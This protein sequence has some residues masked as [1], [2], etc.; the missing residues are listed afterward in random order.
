VSTA[1]PCSLWTG[2]TCATLPDRVVYVSNSEMR[3]EFRECE[4][5]CTCVAVPRRKLDLSSRSLRG[6][7]P[8]SI[9]DLTNIG[10]LFLF[11]NPKLGGTI[12]TALSKLQSAV[13][14]RMYSTAVRLRLH[15]SSPSS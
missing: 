11:N 14:I 9:A 2:V 1:D 4:R 8:D 3:V 15:S 12:P 7:I 5:G 13:D 6:T 10:T